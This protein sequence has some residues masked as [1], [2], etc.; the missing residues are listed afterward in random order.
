MSKRIFTIQASEIGFQGGEYKSD[1][2]SKAA[3][4][5][6][7]RIYKEVNS[8][9][10]LKKYASHDS[11]KFILREKTEGSDKKTFFYEASIKN[12]SKP[13]YI[14]VKS[15]NSANADANGMVK[16]AVTKEVKIATCSENH[17]SHLRK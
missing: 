14:E 8:T 11:I 5:A 6:G 9:P 17:V 12:L 16:Y 13:R 1:I 7:K 10:G 2:P 15:P 4:K 3:K